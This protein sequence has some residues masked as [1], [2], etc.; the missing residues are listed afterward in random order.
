MS[1]VS[2]QATPVTITIT[3]TSDGFAN[4]IQLSVSGLPK[5]ATGLLSMNS[6][7]PGTTTTNVTLMVTATAAGSLPKFP[8]GKHFPTGPWGLLAAILAIGL[9]AARRRTPWGALLPARAVLALR[10]IL[11]AGLAVSL[12]GCGGGFPLVTNATPAGNYTVTVTGT[13]GTLQ[14]SANVTLSIQ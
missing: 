12:S 10:L 8:A 1:V 7:T 2:G 3:P 13:S 4:P 5:G 9:L 14:H 6:V 11:V